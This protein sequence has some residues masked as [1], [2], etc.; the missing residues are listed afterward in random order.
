[1]LCSLLYVVKRVIDDLSG[2]TSISLDVS[3]GRVGRL[4]GGFVLC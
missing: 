3:Q 1:M 4:V 2:E